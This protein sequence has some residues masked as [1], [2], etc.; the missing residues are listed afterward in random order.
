VAGVATCTVTYAGPGSYKIA[1]AYSGDANLLGSISALLT[2]LVLPGLPNTSGPR[3]ADLAAPVAPGRTPTAS[4]LL[5]ALIAGVG[6][7]LAMAIRVVRGNRVRFRKRRRRPRFGA[8]PLLL[9]LSIGVLVAGQS[10][11][12]P[13]LSSP[14]ATAVAGPPAGTELIGTKVV[15][16]AKPT[17]PMAQTFHPSTGPIFPSRLRI[18]S[19]RIDATVV[20]VGL[21]ADGSMDVPANLWTLAWLSSG[22]LPGQAG[23]TVIAGHRGIG[24]PAVFSR[25]EAVRPG[26]RIYVSDPTGSE[27]VYEVTSVVALGLSPSS[28]VAVFGP[29]ASQQLVLI[30]CFGTYSSITGTYDHRLVVFSRLLPPNSG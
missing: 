9:C 19:I 14:Y 13:T 23:S 27:L 30:T 24:T 7:L 15:T 6:G 17:P 4:L 18:P 1:A 10:M 3:V 2:E 12:T 5:L 8:L 20:G 28:Q 16:V 29:T 25:L 11:T 22:A 21:L 26:Q